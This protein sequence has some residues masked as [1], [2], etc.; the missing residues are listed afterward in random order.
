MSSTPAPSKRH[1]AHR[2]PDR[3][4]GRALARRGLRRCP[5]ATRPQLPA[6]P[7]R[8]AL[9]PLRVRL[10]RHPR[11]APSRTRA[12]AAQRHGLARGRHRRWRDGRRAHGELDSLGLAEVLH[13]A[14]RRTPTGPSSSSAPTAPPDA[15]GEW[16]STAPSRP[17][18]A[19]PPSCAG[20]R[21]YRPARRA[22]RSRRRSTC[23]PASRPS[24]ASGSSPGPPPTAVTPSRP[25]GRDTAG[26]DYLLPS[27]SCGKGRGSISAGATGVQRLDH[28]RQGDPERG[29]GAGATVRPRR[30]SGGVGQSASEHAERVEAMQT[31]LR[32]LTE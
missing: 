28:D 3:G 2:L 26:R 15:F 11:P 14:R 23:T 9:L 13:V 16:R 12:T 29:L 22:R 30:R 32:R 4:R 6:G 21:A 25:G 8:P 7:P 27:R 1:L 18:P 31:A 17:G 19:C 10:P 20:P 5:R 24:S